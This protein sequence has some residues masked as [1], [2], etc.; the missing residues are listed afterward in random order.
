LHGTPRQFWP[1]VFY[2]YSLIFEQKFFTELATNS[3]TPIDL[4]KLKT[5]EVGG[6]TVELPCSRFDIRRLIWFTSNPAFF[7]K[8]P[9]YSRE[10]V[11]Q[12]F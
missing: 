7:E 9:V 2:F 4:F 5:G 10:R 6:L 3:S 12:L 8:S 1:G 11:I